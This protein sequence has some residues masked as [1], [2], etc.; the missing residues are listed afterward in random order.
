MP[1]AS[2]VRRKP[3]PVEIASAWIGG[4]KVR[5]SIYDRDTLAHG[6]AIKGPAII[7]EY[8]STTLVPLEFICRVDSFSNLVIEPR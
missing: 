8:S 7:G 1:K 6:H 2:R 4:K 3:E 5:T